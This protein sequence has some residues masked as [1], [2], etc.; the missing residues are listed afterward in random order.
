MFVYGFELVE[1]NEFW[2][3]TDIHKGWILL[4][5]LVVGLFVVHAFGKLFDEFAFI[6]VKGSLTHIS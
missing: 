2:L 4:A 3:E 5:D 6:W 1:L